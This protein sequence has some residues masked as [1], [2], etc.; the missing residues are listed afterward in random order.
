MYTRTYNYATRL[1]AVQPGFAGFCPCCYGRRIFPIERRMRNGRRQVQMM[2][3]HC[4]ELFWV[5]EDDASIFCERYD[6]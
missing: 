5:N 6:W 4:L 1:E 3:E 2:C